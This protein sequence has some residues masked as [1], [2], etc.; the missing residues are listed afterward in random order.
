MKTSSFIRKFRPLSN[1]RIRERPVR[2]KTITIG[3]PILKS[4]MENLCRYNCRDLS[5]SGQRTTKLS[6]KTDS[7]TTS[8]LGLDIG[9]NTASSDSERSENFFSESGKRFTQLYLSDSTSGSMR[10]SNSIYDNLNDAETT[11]LSTS[12]SANNNDDFDQMQTPNNTLNL[13]KRSDSFADEMDSLQKGMLEE[14]ESIKRM[15]SD[16]NLLF[17]KSD[18]NLERPKQSK[19]ETQ[20]QTFDCLFGDDDEID[21]EHQNKVELFIP[22]STYDASSTR[23]FSVS[24]DI[25]ESMCPRDEADSRGPNSTIDDSGQESDHFEAD[26]SWHVPVR[27]R[28]C[29][30]RL[31]WKSFYRDHQPSFR[32]RNV[33]LSNLSAGQVMMLRKIAMLRLTSYMERYSTIR[34]TETMA[35]SLPFKLN[36]KRLKSNSLR[37]KKNMF[38]VSL[39]KNTQNYGQPLPLPMQRA[40]QYLRRNAMTQQG[41][42]RKSGVKTRIQKLRQ[43]MEANAEDFEFQFDNFSPYDIADVVKGYFRDLPEPLMTGK[44]SQTFTSIFLDI[45]PQYWLK[46]VQPAIMLLPDE[47]REVLQTLLYFLSDVAG[48]SDE[49][50]MTAD[51]L[52]VCFAPSLFQLNLN[53]SR[54]SGSFLRRRNGSSNMPSPDESTRIHNESVAAH[55]CFTFMIKECKNL[56][57]ISKEIITQCNL[58]VMEQPEDLLLA[59][60]GNMPSVQQLN[61][62]VEKKLQ[63]DYSS[64]SWSKYQLNASCSSV[65]VHTRKCDDDM[66]LKLFRCRMAIQG[67]PK[68]ILSAILHERSQ[69]DPDLLEMRNIDNLDE[70]SDMTQ[71]VTG[72]MSPHPHRD[73]VVYRAWRYRPN[74]KCELFVTSTRHSKAPLIGDVRGVILLS[75]WT[76]E[77][78]ENGKSYLTHITRFDTRGRDPKW[79][80]RVAGNQLATE[81]RRIHEHLAKS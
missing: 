71:Y 7:D 1:H 45:P 41:L 81:I 21:D 64:S 48:K 19:N 27:T 80:D 57:R 31:R 74:G 55:K 65:S 6:D 22:E 47:N 49:N 69:W 12:L 25:S 8:G 17:E 24:A 42:F 13:S 63:V 20:R 40:L 30:K 35:W 60:L 4:G 5:T 75:Q 33:Q 14:L 10:R 32:S 51:N 2:K 46:A 66:P 15:L 16:V 29:R 38:G 61:K 9:L 67:C 39:L 37:A 26:Q 73:Y 77:P 3:N 11:N 18:D 68:D 52:A 79:Y 58:G 56:F 28:S 50:S 23:S 36:F 54:S 34:N 44:L 70:T 72:S 53:S 76:I 59:E 43:T 78:L 62:F